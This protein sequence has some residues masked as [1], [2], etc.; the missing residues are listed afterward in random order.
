M[1]LSIWR[2]TPS[3]C[4]SASPALSSKHAQSMLHAPGQSSQAKL[5]KAYPFGR[6]A[7]LPQL[8]KGALAS[9]DLPGHV[10]VTTGCAK[11]SANACLPQA[12]QHPIHTQP[13]AQQHKPAPGHDS[14]LHAH[15]LCQPGSI[16]D[17]S[18]D[19]AMAVPQGKSRPGMPSRSFP[20]NAPEN[21]RQPG[22]RHP[23]WQARGHA[24]PS[25]HD[26]NSCLD[27]QNGKQ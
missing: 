22:I 9:A 8:C 20:A 15:T 16:L 7:S 18:M 27:V 26:A 14:Y 10:Q 12:H 3:F 4:T 2:A 5:W 19:H 21:V 24:V 11:A 25:W 6:C 1:T 17:G 13:E 23:A